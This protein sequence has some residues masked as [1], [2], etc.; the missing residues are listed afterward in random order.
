[1]NKK[2]KSIVVVTTILVVVTVAIALAA[3]HNNEN[4]PEP[5]DLLTSETLYDESDL[6]Y[7]EE[8]PRAND[9]ILSQT[10]I[11]YFPEYRLYIENIINESPY[12]VKGKVISIDYEFR[13]KYNHKKFNRFALGDEKKD[14]SKWMIYTV[15][16]VEVEDILRGDTKKTITV[17]RI[18]NTGD[19]QFDKQQSTAEKCGF[20]KI[21]GGTFIPAER[22]IKVEVGEKCTFLIKERLNDG[23]YLLACKGVFPVNSN[24]GHTVDSL[25]NVE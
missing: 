13:N 6:E 22:Y 1:M 21:H 4:D 18:G 25:L 10:I 15:Y 23:T 9:G 5:Y 2:I 20:A 12:V 16:T 14:I 8:T 19:F 17:T 11:G 3:L 7:H 24:N